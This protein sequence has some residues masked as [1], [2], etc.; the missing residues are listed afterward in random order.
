MYA[1]I[2]INNKQY[3]V[4]KKQNILTEKISKKI[5]KKFLIK[6]KNIILLYYKNKILYKKKDIK[7]F[8]IKIKILNQIKKKKINIIKFKRRKN[9]KKK[10]GHRQ[11]LTEI[12]IEYIKNKYGS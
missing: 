4:K 12:K 9:Y 3:K 2:K 8:K 11:K 7:N 5:G 1:I 10:Y 6:N